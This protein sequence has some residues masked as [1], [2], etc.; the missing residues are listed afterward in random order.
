MR[1]TKPFE[2]RFFEA[3]NKDGIFNERL[4]SRCWHWTWYC[5]PHSYGLI[6]RD[7][8]RIIA[9]RASWM[10]HYGDIPAG[11]H[12][13]HHCDNHYCVNPEHLYL[14]TNLDNARD[15]NERGNNNIGIR[16][17]AAKLNEEKVLQIR[18]LY[19]TKLY[20]QKQIADMFDVAAGTVTDV[21]S[22]KLWKRSQSPEQKE[23]YKQTKK[24]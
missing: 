20:T 16:N 23:Y 7:D 15:R 19:Q 4:G 2:E 11:L 14:G 5:R 1:K 17:K 12:V 9:H 8:K 22:G 18:T 10:I 13:L 24:R 3:V 21:L 6:E